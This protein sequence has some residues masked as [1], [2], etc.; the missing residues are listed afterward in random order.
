MAAK[1]TILADHMPKNKSIL[2]IDGLPPL[3]CV[4]IT[5]P[6]VST[7]VTTRPDQTVQS[8]G[9]RA[10]VEITF[11]IP[12]HHALEVFAMDQWIRDCLDPIAVTAKKNGRVIKPSGTSLNARIWAILGAVAV[13]F[14]PDDGEMENE[15]EMSV[16][17]YK[18][19]CDDLTL[20][21]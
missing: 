1:G 14:K 17:A 13:S 8:G 12:E 2:M 4:S 5:M 6:E 9:T 7:D 18:L 20:Q 19:M 10:P 3:T 21:A 16:V 15:G 11:S